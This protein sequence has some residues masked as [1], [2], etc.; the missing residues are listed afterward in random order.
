MPNHYHLLLSPRIE[1]GIAKFIHKLDM[2]YSKYF[3]IKHGRKGTLFEG[4]YK[5]ILIE[6]EPHFYHLPYIYCKY[7]SISV[8]TTMD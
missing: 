8:R 1:K 2:G 3:N 7:R 4:R 5:S 6:K